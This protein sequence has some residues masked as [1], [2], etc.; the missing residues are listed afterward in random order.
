M[1]G[2]GKKQGEKTR[3]LLHSPPPAGFWD[4]G[5]SYKNSQGCL[6]GLSNQPSPGGGGGG[7]PGKD[8]GG[9]N[10]FMEK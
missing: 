6:N 2:G 1:V 8:S 7:E 3:K 10:Q 9:G 4:G 5:K